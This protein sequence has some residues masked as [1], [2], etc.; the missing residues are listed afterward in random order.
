MKEYILGIVEEKEPFTVEV[1]T[2]GEVIEKEVDDIKRF[3]KRYNSPKFM[4]LLDLYERDKVAYV[5]ARYFTNNLKIEYKDKEFYV[6]NYNKIDSKIVECNNY[7]IINI[8]K[9]PL[10]C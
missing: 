10:H 6:V 3:L 9:K 4:W 7:N 2:L 8:E 5:N 1:K